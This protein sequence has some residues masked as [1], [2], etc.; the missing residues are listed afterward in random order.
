M[1]LA[2]QSHMQ[3]RSANLDKLFAAIRDQHSGYEIVD[4]R[5]LANQ[6]EA[7]GQDVE[8]LDVDFA[9]AVEN[10]V[11]ISVDELATA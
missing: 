10:A 1:C 11:D 3:N 9:Q 8:Q 2:I 5:L 7:N 6:N 4:F